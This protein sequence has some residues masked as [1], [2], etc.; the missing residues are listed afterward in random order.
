MSRNSGQ[1]MVRLP[2]GTGVD[3][4]CSPQMCGP[5]HMEAGPDA[6]ASG[7]AVL[8]SLGSCRRFAGLVKEPGVG[9]DGQEGG[10]LLAAGHFLEQLEG[11]VKTV[12]VEAF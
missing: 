7:P 8:P 3:T 10:E 11:V 12:S 5:G 1:S 9:R 4:W 6:F 2:V